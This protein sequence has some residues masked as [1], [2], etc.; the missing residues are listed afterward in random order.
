[1]VITIIRLFSRL[2]IE[3]SFFLIHSDHWMFHTLAVFRW[4]DASIM[5]LKFKYWENDSSRSLFSNLTDVF[6]GVA[7]PVYLVCEYYNF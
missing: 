7:S 4:K 6:L 2:Y 5:Y 1:M 3:Y